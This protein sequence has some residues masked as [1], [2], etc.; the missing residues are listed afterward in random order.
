M[1][2]F[3]FDFGDP[4]YSLAD[5]QLGLQV[6][7]FENTYGLDP[8]SANVQMQNDSLLLEADGLTWAGGQEKC[9][10]RATL[11]ARRTDDGLELRANPRACE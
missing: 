2:Q 3:S 10:G 6:I 7:T 11:M 5:W 1:H 4:F 9:L 8:A